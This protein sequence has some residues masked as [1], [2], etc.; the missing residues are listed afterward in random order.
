MDNQRALDDYEQEY[1]DIEEDAEAAKAAKA[2]LKEQRE[3]LND[4]ISNKPDHKNIQKW[5]K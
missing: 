1:D 5:K 2:Y 3:E 4:K